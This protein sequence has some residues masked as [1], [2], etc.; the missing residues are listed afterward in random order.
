MISL[1]PINFAVTLSALFVR[2]SSAFST[3][4]P[5]TFGLG[6]LGHRST[7]RLAS[8]ALDLE[9]KFFQLEELEDKEDCTTEVFLAKDKTVE[10]GETDGPIALS[11]S[12]TWSISDEGEFRMTIKRKFN[13]GMKES[14]FTDM[15]EFDFEV[16][17]LY[18]GSTTLVGELA[19]VNGAMLSPDDTFGD[20]EVGFFNMLDTTDERLDLGMDGEPKEKEPKKRSMS[21]R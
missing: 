6:Q 12:G 20:M 16:E 14:T 1:V 4:T 10:V 7:T 2:N 17:R 19:A 21:S 8:A 15:G 13:A 5:S 18:V 11:A 3:G 9:S